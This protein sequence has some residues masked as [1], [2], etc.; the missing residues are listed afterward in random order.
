MTPQ[1]NLLSDSYAFL[2]ASEPKGGI[3]LSR[4]FKP[5]NGNFSLLSF[6]LNREH[7]DLLTQN[8]LQK[9]VNTEEAVMLHHRALY[10]VISVVV[11]LDL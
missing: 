11:R 1:G 5:Q 4:V 3:P 8:K 2:C 7:K 10:E 6:N 9:H